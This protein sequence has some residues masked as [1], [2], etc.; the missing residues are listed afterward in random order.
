MGFLMLG[1]FANSLESRKVLL[2]QDIPIEVVSVDFFDAALNALSRRT[3]RGVRAMSNLLP[4]PFLEA[5]EIEEVTPE[6]QT[7]DTSPEGDSRLLGGSAPMHRQ[8]LITR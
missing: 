1:L 3:R 2:V 4:F 8:G 7:S 5:C 6:V